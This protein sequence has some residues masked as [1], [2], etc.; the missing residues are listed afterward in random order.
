MRQKI[1]TFVTNGNP[2]MAR[3]EQV[4]VA[5]ARQFGLGDGAA[6]I[7][8]VVIGA[9]VY[10]TSP[11][12]AA[13][14]PGPAWLVPIWMAGALISLMG[15]LAYA[16]IVTRL[17]RAGGDY[18]Y[19]SAAYGPGIG[20]LFAWVE[21]WLIHPANI[22]AIAFIFGRYANA[23]TG[24]DG[25]IMPA[26]LAVIV[27][28]LVHVVGVRGGRWTQNLLAA[29]KVLSLAGLATAGLVWG[30]A[31]ALP[32]PLDEHS[33]DIPLALILVLF[34]YGGW[35][36]I[37]YIATEVRE[38]QRN[39]PRALLLGIGS[40]GLIY[41][42]VN[43]AFTN[44]LGFAGTAASESVAA[45]MLSRITG[46]AGG[47]VISLLICLACL[48]NIN[49]MILIGSRLLYAVGRDHRDFAWMGQWHG[50][51]DAPLMALLVQMAISVSMIM[52]V[53]SDG[54]GFE[55]LVILSMPLFW[56]FFTLVAI[57]LFVF[58]YRADE[59]IGYKTPFYPWLPALFVVFCIAIFAISLDYARSRL[60]LELIWIVIVLLSGI[61]VRLW[62]R[63]RSL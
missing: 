58:R 20:F 36:S 8:G 60:S 34:T 2:R 14:L 47:I 49:G 39:I 23:I 19:L 11:T 21:F 54:H 48:G 26:V 45:D 42:L 33:S 3:Q 30:Q 46:A 4:A 51:L 44:T 22:G 53:G 16:E 9:G 35:S 62:Q 18:A 63:S 10:E 27:L 61:A 38:P 31:L 7:V 6:V 52:L 37:A 56:G 40:V 41:V 5:P 12:I 15:A 24:A 57:S 43:L 59:P 55:R 13:S 25:R 50:R 32:A 29:I 28:T 17:P 1:Y